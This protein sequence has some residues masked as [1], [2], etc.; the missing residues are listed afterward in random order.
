M[1]DTGSMVS[2]IRKSEGD[3]IDTS[4][5]LQA[6]NGSAIKCY[7]QKKVNIR[8]GRKT[9]DIIATIADVDQDIL[10]WDFIVKHRL[11]IEW[12]EFG[13]LILHDKR[14]KIKAPMKCVALPAEF[15]QTSAFRTRDSAWCSSE[16][17]EVA[18]MKLLPTQGPD[19]NPI[20]PKYQRLLDKFPD[21]SPIHVVC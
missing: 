14:S 19:A 3:K 2:V 20:Q 15:P 7:G 12:G 18:A 5:F 4:K 17:F 11:N 10:G 13:D 1:C 21:I 8:L 16:A 6:V 9:Y